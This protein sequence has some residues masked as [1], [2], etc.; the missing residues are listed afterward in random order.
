MD[1]TT[2]P[3]EH[4]YAAARHEWDERYGDLITRAR[5][6][7]TMAALGLAAMLAAI[8]DEADWDQFVR[9]PLQIQRNPHAIR[10]A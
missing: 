2:I 7:R 5:N 3:L 10:G 4:P 8:V 1:H 6:W 9:Q